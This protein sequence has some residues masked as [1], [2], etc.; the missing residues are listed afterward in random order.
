V[1]LGGG[2]INVMGSQWI[3]LAG[4]D[5]RY[6]L[7]RVDDYSFKLR[8]SDNSL[9]DVSTGYPAFIA[10]DYTIYAEVTLKV[11]NL[12]PVSCV[13]PTGGTFVRNHALTFNKAMTGIYDATLGA[14]L[15]GNYD[16]ANGWW[17]HKAGVP[18]EQ[19]VELCKLVGAHPWISLPVNVDASYMTS[20]LTLLRDIQPVWMKPIVEFGNEVWGGTAPAQYCDYVSL[21]DSTFG[22][23]RNLHGYYGKSVA[24]LGKTIQTVYAGSGK[25]CETSIGHQTVNANIGTLKERLKAKTYSGYE[26]QSFD[27]SKSPDTYAA[28]NHFDTYCGPKLSN[29]SVSG[30]YNGHSL[31]EMAYLWTYGTTN[32]KEIAYRWLA[33]TCMYC[34]DV[35]MSSLTAYYSSGY[36]PAFS[37]NLKI[38]TYEG[39]QIW[40][41]G[42]APGAPSD[43]TSGTTTDSATTATYSGAYGTQPVTKYNVL[44]FMLTF[45]ETWHYAAVTEG[46]FDALKNFGF[47]MPSVFCAQ[48]SDDWGLW[49]TDDPDAP[50]RMAARAF[51]EC[52]AGKKRV[53]GTLGA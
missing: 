47:E 1:I 24:I 7:V 30:T 43:Y 40:F 18:I 15:L 21:F 10:G 29:T 23:V 5:R 45:K 37:P 35:R 52:G 53:R 3:A 48:G 2:D 12:P 6:T 51:F 46:L 26:T 22:G 49:K 32:E 8:K 13:Q 27:L 25:T 31:L 19:C 14:L 50:A 11:G 44:D 16:G 41:P 34:V 20:F 36:I 17:N 28:S 42:G 39:G 38:R 4:A 9:L 33:D